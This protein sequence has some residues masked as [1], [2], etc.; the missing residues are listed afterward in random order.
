MTKSRRE[1][2]GTPMP[3]VR[4]NLELL[5]TKPRRPEDTLAEARRVMYELAMNSKDGTHCPCCDRPFILRDRPLHAGMA[6]G[7]IW[8][9]RRH[10][11]RG[12]V[13][14]NMPKDAPRHVIGNREIEKLA[15]WGMV[16][17]RSKVDPGP[18]RRGFWRVTSFGFDFADRKVSAPRAAYVLN[19]VVKFMASD[20][21][22]ISQALGE[23]Y[24]YYDLMRSP[25][26]PVPD[27]SRMEG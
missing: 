11:E 26:Q 3:M 24:S 6:A 18:G 1:I 22:T 7:L 27:D 20:Q 12:D 21:I 10:R 15:W 17:A 25:L 9:V 13:W 14:V 19:R 23:K 5:R 8:M 16:E 2:E 4:R